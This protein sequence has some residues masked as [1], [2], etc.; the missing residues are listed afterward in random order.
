MRDFL[1]KFISI[2]LAIISIII[3][4]IFIQNIIY[5]GKPIKVLE[6]R[7]ILLKKDYPTLELNK[8]DIVIT[9]GNN[10]NKLQKDQ[11]IAYEYGVNKIGFSKVIEI[12]N[13]NITIE[14]IENIS[15]IKKETV[16]G[17]VDVKISKIGKYIV[18][19]RSVKG[20][21]ISIGIIFA[22]L[23]VITSFTKTILFIKKLFTKKY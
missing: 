13:E 9:N 19:F 5:N 20:F 21:L 18:Y 8:N 2:I 4:L 10:T 1:V 22:I 6:Y 3:F 23:L 15:T 12:N 17:P 16:Y 14:K 7:M 11:I